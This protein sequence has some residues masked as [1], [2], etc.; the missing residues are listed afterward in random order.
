MKLD[1]RRSRFIACNTGKLKEPW[2][3]ISM[4]MWMHVYTVVS[5]ISAHGRLNITHNFDP[6]GCLRGTKIP[7]VCIEAVTVALEMSYMGAYPGVGACPGH[8]MVLTE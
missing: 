1:S 4:C 2:D 5:W 3:N 7:Y 6:H 8:Y